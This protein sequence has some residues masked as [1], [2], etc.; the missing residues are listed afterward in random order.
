MQTYTI[1]CLK[2][3]GSRNIK[4]YQMEMR[5]C[6]DWMENQAP[7]P[8]TIISGRERLDGQWGFQCMCGNNDLLTNQESSTFSNPATPQ[9]QELKEI[10][11]N[12]IIDN[13]KFEMMSL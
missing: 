4:I 3:K 8:A 13:P 5:K 9:P 11:S 2:C 10:L 7:S 1:T 6:I 12:L